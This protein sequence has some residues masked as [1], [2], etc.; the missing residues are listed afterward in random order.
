MTTIWKNPGFGR[1]RALGALWALWLAAVTLSACL[2]VEEQKDAVRRD[3]LSAS[4]HQQALGSVAFARTAQNVL[5]AHPAWQ[6]ASLATGDFNS[7]GLVVPSGGGVGTRFK[8]GY[9]RE[10]TSDSSGKFREVLTVW[11]ES[12]NP[13][14][15]ELQG[16]GRNA[17]PLLAKEMANLIGESA[18]GVMRAGTLM[19]AGWNE[20]IHTTL[21]P[22]ECDS[23]ALPEGTPVLAME[24]MRKDPG[25]RKASELVYSFRDCGPSEEGAVIRSIR[26]NKDEA[27]VGTP[28]GEK[29]FRDKCL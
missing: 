28:E 8:A 18:V 4:L 9:C 21:L 6:D 12:V 26:S 25:T 7:L 19:T 14:A 23:L 1:G 10:S 17:G 24:I 22:P 3:F 20:E 15:F 27:G 5:V 13:A 16:V 29:L 11:P 2:P